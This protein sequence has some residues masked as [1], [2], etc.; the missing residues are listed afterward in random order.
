MLNLPSL[1]ELPAGTTTGELAERF[2]AGQTF[3]Y[4]LPQQ[5]VNRLSSQGID[6]R[7]Q[8][9][10]GYAEGDHFGAPWPLTREAE[11]GLKALAR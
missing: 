5:W 7:G 11:L 8:V 2:Y 6:V 10:W 9:V 4:A 1:S 3:D